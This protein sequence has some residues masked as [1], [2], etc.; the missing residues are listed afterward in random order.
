M[1]APT[2]ADF[3]A[4][5]ARIAHI[6]RRTPLVRAELDGDA[7]E[8]WLKLE[9]LQPIGAFKIRGAA[10]A[11]MSADRAALAGGVITASAGNMAQG[12]AWCARELGVRCRV[13]V[14]DHAPRAKTDAIERLGGEVHKVPFAEWWQTIV[15]HRH[16][17]MEGFF[18]H[19]FAD[20][21]VMAGNG[22]IGLEIAEELQDVDAV[23]VPYGGGG[24]AC[25][26]AAALRA[27]SPRTKVY[28]VEVETAAPL[29]ATFAAGAPTTVTRTKT[30]I[31]GMGS[32][33]VSDEIWP[34]VRTLL[35][36]TVVVSVAQ[37]AAAVKRIAER[38]HVV[39]EG[40]GASPLAA[41]LTLR[42][43]TAR[44]ANVEA[45]RDAKRVVGIVSGGNL[46]S[47]VLATILRGE[48]P[49]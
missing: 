38:V 39:A 43:G 48:L 34:L 16:A 17:G 20:T 11:M 10:N 18:V 13:V 22:T 46:D 3:E 15:D 28:A 27:V 41:A 25:G 19:P 4:A 40:A 8:L 14:P 5:R 49:A 44:G 37:V 6:A 21:A 1:N 26:I 42:S 12:V 31:D 47:D 29:T 45:L 23:L 35:A 32:D 2:L 33:R 24:L 7:P 36:G 9:N 30:F